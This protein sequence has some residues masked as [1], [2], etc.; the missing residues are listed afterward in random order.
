[1]REERKI[2]GRLQVAGVEDLLLVNSSLGQGLVVVQVSTE[3]TEVLNTSDLERSGLDV[4]VGKGLGASQ[5]VVNHHALDLIGAES[6]PWEK[7]HGLGHQAGNG[8][9]N[10]EVTDIQVGG[11]LD[12][13][14][15]LLV[16]VLL[17]TD[18]LKGL[19]NGVLAI[20]HQVHSTGNIRDVNGADLGVTAVNADRKTTAHGET[21]KEAILLTV[22]GRGADNGGAGEDAANELLTLGL[23]AQ[24][25][26]GRV[27]GGVHGR[28]LD[29]AVNLVLLGELGNNTGSLNMDVREREVASLIITA[30][31]VVNGVRVT[32]GSLQ[33]VLVA[34]VNLH[35]DNLSKITH[36]LQ[37][38][39]IILIAVG[40]N[41]VSALASE[42]VD[43]VT[44]K[45]SSAAKNSDDVSVGRRASTT[46]GAD[47]G[48]SSL[49][50]NDQIMREALLNEVDDSLLRLYD[51]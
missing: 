1:M 40:D 34:E 37:V 25:T 22:H 29:E 13:V 21:G 27:D 8:L 14:Q 41:N 4:E 38:A 36:D 50:R 42:T 32:N 35:G 44:S 26:G 45:E 2:M 23:G 6:L 19:A 18:E 30:E 15:Q 24:E 16:G 11:L 12:V 51:N 9:G 49:G 20:E 43:Q 46:T 7:I 3:T 48:A 39:H 33:G 31:Q 47:N 28:H 17:I 5:L 10:V